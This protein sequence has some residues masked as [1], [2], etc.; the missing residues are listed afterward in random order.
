[1]PHSQY[2]LFEFSGRAFGVAWSRRPI[3]PIDPIE[4]KSFRPLH[5]ALNGVESHAKSPCDTALRVAATN[6]GN[7][8]TTLLGGQLF[9]SWFAP[10]A[11]PL[12]IA[13]DRTC[14]KPIDRPRREREGAELQ[15]GYALLP[16]RPLSFLPFSVQSDQ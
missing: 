10:N 6:G 13:V 3:C 16:F 9:D 12:G 11:F 2:F 7:D 15:S 8:A 5:P 4:A 14:C 1:M